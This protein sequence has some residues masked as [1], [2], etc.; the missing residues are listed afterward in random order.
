MAPKHPQSDATVDVAWIIA[1][2]RD[3]GVRLVEVD[4]SRAAYEQG[5]LPGA[6]LGNTYADLRDA[7]YTPVPLAELQRLIS[8]SAITPETTV[9][10]YGYAATARLLGHEGHRP[11]RRAAAPRQARAMGRV[12]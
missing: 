3:P 5:H 11:Q 4:V 12:W 1:H 10:F 2:V 6:V 9:V 7:A 8:R